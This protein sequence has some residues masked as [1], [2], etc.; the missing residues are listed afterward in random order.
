MLAKITKVL[1]GLAMRNW[2]HTMSAFLAVVMVSS[3]ATTQFKNMSSAFASKDI[4]ENVL[5]ELI[6]SIK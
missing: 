1:G 5:I 3:L 2:K 6:G 4:D